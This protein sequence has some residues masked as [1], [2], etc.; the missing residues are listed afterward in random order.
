M[1]SAIALALLASTCAAG[2]G[3]GTTPK[4]PPPAP[5]TA[6]SAKAAGPAA[7]VVV[8]LV[9]DQLAGWV[10]AERLAELPADGGF[11][12]LAREG[13]WVKDMR[14]MHSATDT[15]PGHSSLFTGK[16]PRESGIFG[17]EVPRSKSP[18]SILRD[19][20]IKM[21]GEQGPK[22]KAGSSLA[23]LRVPTVADDL[24][25]KHP[26]AGVVGLSLKDR[27][28]GFGCG[29]RPKACVWFDSGEDA[30]VTSTAFASALPP[31][32]VE[33]A[34]KAAVERARKEPW[35]L[36][37]RA[38]VERH[39]A[40]ADDQ[41]GEGDLGGMKTT[42]PHV[43]ATAPAFRASPFSDAVLLDLARGAIDA[44]YKQ[45]AP[46]LLEVS[47]SAND[48]VGHAFGP[49]SWEAWEELRRV[50]RTI[51][52]LMTTLD[53]R[54]GPA[55][56]SL[57]L[58]ADHGTVTM[59]EV[60]QAAR[61]WCADANGARDPWGR[62]CSA[63]GRILIREMEEAL[64]AEAER[65]LG[66][67]PWI[68]GVADPYYFVTEKAKALDPKR[69]KEL[70][71]AIAKALVR[72]DHALARVDSAEA[73]AARCVDEPAKWDESP[74]ALI[75]RAWPKGGGAGEGYMLP[76]QGCF[77]DPNVVI[78]KG[79]S[80]GSTYLYDRSGPMF[81]RAPGKIT[82]GAREEGPVHFTAYHRVLTALLALS[83]ES[84]KDALEASRKASP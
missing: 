2:C 73:L 57:V 4:T 66:K 21:V 48:I 13:A 65:A 54:F 12:R 82:P 84:P 36:G 51:A 80:H 32:V 67:G 5:S 72:W 6:P 52:D 24:V 71:Q 3:G 38:W 19:D 61:R 46:F 74:N 49:D 56:W 44:E 22:D 23:R 55:G 53:A 29:R 8:A 18:V 28:A 14:Y 9:V 15:A 69:A 60:G 70:S 17:N 76:R 78:G 39:A 64:E 59:P 58:A 31:W 27:G 75:C 63:T 81:V 79:T 7:P 16:P 30:F 47:F 41:T 68:E 33:R 25:A 62:P 83:P 11:A 1:R 40:T 37:D 45:G 77:F 26:A 43:V 10:M 35:A 50:D 34:G 42:F 20:S